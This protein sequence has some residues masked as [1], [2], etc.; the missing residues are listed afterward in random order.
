[1]NDTKEYPKETINIIDVKSPINWDEYFMLLAMMASYR[2]KDPST[3]V[4]CVFVDQN[5]HQ[6]SMG[7]NGFVAGIDETKLPWGKDQSVSME[8]QKYSYVVH[9]EANAILHSK[10]N[11]EGTK[12]YVTLF[13]CHE[14]AKLLASKKVQE[15]IFL[16]NKHQGRESYNIS[17]KILSLSGIKYRQLKLKD[18]LGQDVSEHFTQLTKD[19]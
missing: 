14:C 6:L 5:N 2:S 18:N 13:P 19:L 7:Y 3:K 11:L 1:M 4:G 12:C 17:Q 9:A 16:S 10:S 8:H 15:V